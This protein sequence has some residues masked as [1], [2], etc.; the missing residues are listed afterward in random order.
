[1]NDK[2]LASVDVS[3]PESV[4]NNGTLWAHIFVAQSGAVMDPTD[5]NY[6]TAKAYRTV[7][8]MNR[9]MPKRKV[10]KTKKLVGATEEEKAAAEAVLEAPV[11]DELGNPIIMSYWHSNLT[12]EMVEGEGAVNYAGT[13]P[14][15]V[16]YI[17]LEATGKRD[18]SGKNG[19]YYPIVFMND[20]WLLKEHMVELNSTVT[21]VYLLAWSMFLGGCLQ[22]SLGRSRFILTLNR[23]SG[24][25]SKSMQPSTR[26][27]SR[28][29]LI[30]A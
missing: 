5:E 17:R 25:N 24:G 28:V 11:V 19:W 27:S 2:R 21:Y 12:L 29:H 9:Y 8:L 13:P 30:P 10:V 4:K 3:F 14:P 23:L 22:P 1:M 7:K 15:L 16:K 6:D 20:F 18:A 26:H